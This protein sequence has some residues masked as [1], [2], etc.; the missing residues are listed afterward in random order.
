MRQVIIKVAIVYNLEYKLMFSTLLLIPIYCCST[1]QVTGY[2]YILMYTLF[3]DYEEPKHVFMI[4]EL[5]ISEDR[6]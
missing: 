3:L 6:H 1:V 2:F 4:D 5:N